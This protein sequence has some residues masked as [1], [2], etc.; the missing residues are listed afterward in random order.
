M[1]GI[2]SMTGF[3]KSQ[4]QLTG[5]KVSIELK[6]LNS[7]QAD[8]NF[9][10]PNELRE[11]EPLLRQQLLEGLQ[12]GKIDCS[13]QSE[14][15]DGAAAPSIN[16]DLAVQY[17]NQFRRLTERSGTQGDALGA[18]MRLPDILQE[19]DK[20]LNEQE[21]QQLGEA[22]NEAMD[23]L[24]Q[25]RKS[26]GQRLQADLQQRIQTIAAKLEQI[27]PL[28]G[29]R[30][31]Q[32]KKRLENNLEQ[33]QASADRDRLEQ[34]MV[35]Y[36]EKLDITEEKVRLTSHL[37]YFEDLLQEGGAVGKKLGFVSQEIG[38]EINTLGSK[39]N[40]API[41]KLVV[42]MKDELEKIK[43]QVLNIL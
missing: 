11:A 28:E 7:K 3:G 35:Y 8:A 21:L 19:S 23:Q 26:E 37:Q 17:L 4:V 2:Q 20:E 38:R 25:F 42:E 18:L 43:E 12:R 1:A 34:E 13:I 22:L 29:E 31:E 24:R 9:R 16:E 33:L 30:K 36:L 5:R 27:T 32:V 39:A 41:Q 14:V 15:T 40:H 10:L 6:S